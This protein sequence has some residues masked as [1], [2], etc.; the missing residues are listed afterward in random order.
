MVAKKKNPAVEA[1]R[2]PEAIAARKATRE[3]NSSMDIDFSTGRTID[4]FPASGRVST[5]AR[6][7]N[8]LAESVINGDA[9]DGVY[10]QVGAFTN[11]SSASAAKKRITEDLQDQLRADVEFE[12]R[13]TSSHENGG[14]L[15]AAVFTEDQAAVFTEDQEEAE[16]DW[17]TVE[18]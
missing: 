12:L 4:S 3:T 13:T 10:Y 7:L 5:W 11:M 8:A 17:D 1:A 6:K 18:E 9:K 16:G 14:E 2:S 15:W